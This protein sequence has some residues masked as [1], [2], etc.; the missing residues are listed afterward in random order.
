MGANFIYLKFTAETPRD[1]IQRLF[2]EACERDRAE[3]GRSYSGSIGMFNGIAGWRDLGLL[4]EEAA[5]EWLGDNHEKWDNA[6]AVSFFMKIEDTKS[7]AR[8]KE[9]WDKAWK[10]EQDVRIVFMKASRPFVTCKDCGS[11]L[12]RMRLP[13]AGVCP[14]CKRNLLGKTAQLKIYNAKDKAA[15]FEESMKTKGK[16]GIKMWMIGGLVPS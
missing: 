14:I 9:L 1:Q 16:K 10:V 7:Q 15:R 12:L 5:D 2:N 11:R 4:G 6:L 8:L 3:N 13:E